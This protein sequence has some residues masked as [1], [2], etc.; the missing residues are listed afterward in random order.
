MVD[1]AQWQREQARRVAA[2]RL[3]ATRTARNAY[4][5]VNEISVARKLLMTLMVLGAVSSAVGAGTFAAFTATTT[6]S[7]TFQ[8]GSVIL[9]DQKGAA[10]ACVSTSSSTD[11]NSNNGCDVLFN[12]SSN[13]SDQARH[14]GESDSVTMRLQNSGTLPGTLT[15]QS[16]ANCTSA[17]PT[18]QSQAFP[19]G[20][21]DDCDYVQLSISDST[22]CYWGD[23]IGSS[24]TAPY[25]T[26]APLTF[27][28]VISS[29]AGGYNRFKITVDGVAH[30]NVVIADGSYANAAALT[31]A[32]NN[33]TNGTALSTW[34]TASVTASNQLRIT[35]KTNTGSSNVTLNSASTNADH[36]AL[37]LLGFMDGS[38]AAG[39]GRCAT[40]TGDRDH[41]LADF[42]TTT[43]TTPL[44]LGTLSAL[45]SRDFT[46]S[47]SVAAV[48]GD[49][50]QARMTGFELTWLL[51][52]S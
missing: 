43:Q 12:A 47:V 45:S 35:S 44:A 18:G 22:Q 32:I 8:S 2:S 9:S 51:T 25:V 11:T 3:N 40:K 4:N 6:R 38:A 49:Q 5:R 42:R 1:R 24:S 34:A 10:T 31:T 27:P 21:S 7:A 23:N 36:T 37:N 20:T 39:P 13:A 50:N 33:A 16:A 41:T 17:D 14:P 15:L 30:D 46:V 19:F 52:Q 29:G 28:V 48:I 26:G